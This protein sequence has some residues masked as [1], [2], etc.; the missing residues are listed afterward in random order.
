[1]LSIVSAVPV[2]PYTFIHFSS[3]GLSCFLPTWKSTS[4]F[5]KLSG[6]VRST[7]PKSCGSISLKR[8]LPRVDSIILSSSTP[9]AFMPFLLTLILAWSVIAPFSYAIIAS[10]TFLNDLPSPLAPGRSCVR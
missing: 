3:I 5:K 8:N 2:A 7:N 4:S 1:M 6:S 9:L 10:F